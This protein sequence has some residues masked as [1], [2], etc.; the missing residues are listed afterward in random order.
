MQNAVYPLNTKYV[1]HASF[2]PYELLLRA[3]PNH[4]PADISPED[5]VRLETLSETLMKE[6]SLFDISD[7]DVEQ[8]AIAQ[9]ARLDKM[10]LHDLKHRLH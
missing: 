3:Q 1:K 2:T 8:V 7:G 6:D 9:L 4:T 10:R 5:R